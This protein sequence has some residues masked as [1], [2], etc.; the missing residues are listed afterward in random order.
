MPGQK[1]VIVAHPERGLASACKV[2]LSGYEVVTVATLEELHR[3]ADGT[4]DGII[5]S[6]CFPAHH[7]DGIAVA[8]Q[9]A[10]DNTAGFRGAVVGISDSIEHHNRF[11]EAGINA[12]NRYGQSCQMLET[13]L[14]E[15][16]P[17]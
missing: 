16:V 9:Y 8:K 12:S 7:G 1:R 5:V 11:V 6:C 10:G 17:A 4:F 15:R 3:T 2:R 14:L 13:L